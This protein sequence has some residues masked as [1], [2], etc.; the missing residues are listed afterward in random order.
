MQPP[1]GCGGIGC[2]EEALVEAA[3][4]GVCVGGGAR[5]ADPFAPP[6][7]PPP[8]TKVPGP[9]PQEPPP[10]FGAIVSVLDDDDD[11][12]SPGP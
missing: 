8:E 6:P 12:L 4:L 1:S 5:C 10:P 11:V 2:A 3:R 7:P 9:P